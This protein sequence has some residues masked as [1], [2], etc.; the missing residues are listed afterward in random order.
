METDCCI[1][2]ACDYTVYIALL[3]IVDANLQTY[4]VQLCSTM[5]YYKQY[6]FTEPK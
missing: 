2:N 5:P 1:L 3:N 4:I 6:I